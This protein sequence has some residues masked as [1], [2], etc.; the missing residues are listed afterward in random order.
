MLLPGAALHVS[1]A[2]SPPLTFDRYR[3]ECGLQKKGFVGLLH[4]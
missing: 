4:I 1:A 2:P 3:L